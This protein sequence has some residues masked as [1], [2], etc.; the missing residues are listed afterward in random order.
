MQTARLSPDCGYSR[1]VA[2]I[3]FRSRENLA[4][5]DCALAAVADVAAVAR[6]LAENGAVDV[7]ALALQQLAARLCAHHRRQQWCD[8][9][10]PASAGEEPQKLAGIA[11]RQCVAARVFR[12]ETASANCADSR[13]AGPAENRP[14]NCRSSRNSTARRAVGQRFGG[15]G[16]VR[17]A[18]A[19][20]GMGSSRTAVR[21]RTSSKL[22]RQR[23]T[24]AQAMASSF[25]T[26]TTPP[27]GYQATTVGYGSAG[28]APRSHPAPHQAPVHRALL[29]RCALLRLCRY[30]PLRALKRGPPM[31]GGRGVHS[32]QF[33]QPGDLG[34][35]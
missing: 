25:Y 27:V 17:Y 15:D 16:T 22:G 26:S 3:A 29:G 30:L 21:G 24:H 4:G 9:L 28:A 32:H 19:P 35:Q 13:I 31:I 14:A 10:R 8:G 33:A 34:L 6:L 7:A 11:A 1:P 2:R 12:A 23:P 5:A 20:L 18:S